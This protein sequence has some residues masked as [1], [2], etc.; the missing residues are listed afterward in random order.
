MDTLYRLR[1]P[2]IFYPVNSWMPVP[3][4]VASRVF[5]KLKQGRAPHLY[6]AMYERATR[7]RSRQFSMNLREL[8]ELVHCDPRTARKCF[9]ELVE[10][11]FVKIV[12]K[13]GANRSRT[14]KPK[15]RVPLCELEL[16]DGGWFPVPRFLV[17]RYLPKFP[18]SLLLIILISM[19]HQKWNDHCW[20]GVPYLEKI[21][22]WNSRS[23]YHALN[24]MGHR[25][26]WKKLGTGLPWPLKILYDEKLERRHFS[27][28][29][30][31]YYL[32]ATRRRKVVALSEEFASHFGYDKTRSKSTKE[33]EE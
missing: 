7:V 21:T 33:T 24:I 5:A 19:Q 4:E 12:H 2:R 9:I 8:G 17:T 1:V 25:H 22:N 31:H 28:R 13:G 18:G 20:M 6:M 10:E 3:N 14:D 23:I 27:V 16:A 26:K 32:P 30:V 15:F 29:A 11:G